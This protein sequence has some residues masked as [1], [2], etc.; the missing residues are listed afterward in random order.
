MAYWR[1][2][3]TLVP[4]SNKISF[5]GGFNNGNPVVNVAENQSIAEYGWET[6]SYPALHTIKDRT[7]YGTGG[8]AQTN[9][10]TNFGTFHMVRAV[11]TALQYWNGSVWTAITGTFADTDWDATNFEVSGSP[12]LVLT[13]GTDNVKY[14]NGTV[15]ADLNGT[16]APK[17]KY[18]VNDTLRV[19]IA[20]DDIIYFSKYL[21]ATNWTDAENSGSV[22]YYTPN[23]GNIT[24]MKNFNNNKFVWKSDS[25]AAIFGTDFFNYRL[26]EISDQIGCVSNKTVQE[27]ATPQG[28]VLFWLGQT[29]VYFSNGGVPV[30]MGQSIRGYLDAINRTYWS[31]CFGATDGFR[32]YLGLVT[33]ANTQPDTF[34]MYDPRYR[35]WRV[36]K[37]GDNLRYSTQF[38]GNVYAG[39]ANGQTYQLNAAYSTSTQWMYTTKDFDEG[40]PEHEKECYELYLQ[41]YTPTGSTFTVQ[42]STD[43]GITWTTVGAPITTAAT[44]QSVPII[45]PLDTIPIG[46][47]TRFRLTGTGEVII[48][49]AQRY[50]RA[51]P[52]QY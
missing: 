46:Y 49:A 23:G 45:V 11:G 34:L 29:D 44:N 38:N 18:I 28:S 25:M 31:R 47:W 12:A 2:S 20:K 8:S 10:L 32:Y 26:V 39:D 6:N 3:K 40:L 41:M 14:W 50:F 15:L 1:A 16:N 19:W 33:G 7:A 17:G 36:N 9:L 4:R 35:I 27:V 42:V 24:A 5:E 30:P 22:Q 21:D 52:A 43:Q 37:I 13:N 48:Y 51:H